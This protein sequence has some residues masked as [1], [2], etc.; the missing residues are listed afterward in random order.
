MPVWAA[1]ASVPLLG[2]RLTLNVVAGLVL[3]MTGLGVLIGHDMAVLGSAPVG[4]AFMLGAAISW[5]IGTVLFKLFDWRLPIATII[6]WQ[7]LLA[8]VPVGAGALLLEPA[9]DLTT[10]SGPAIIALVYVLA[11]P[12]VFCQWAY[13]KIV[14]MF[15]AVY[16]AVGVLAVPLVGVISSLIV[17]GEPVGWREVVALV[18]VTSAIFTVL[19]LPMLSRK[20]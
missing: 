13:F 11:F 3:G 14:R 2:G 16:A 18:L 20:A 17:L 12:M 10:L 1:L 7:L 9:P 6:G 4:A 19:I 15:P 5:G 8:S